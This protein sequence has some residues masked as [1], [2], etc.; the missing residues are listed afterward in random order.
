MKKFFWHCCTAAFLLS[1]ATVSLAA[2]SYE[3]TLLNQIN[4][5]RQKHHL[6]PLQLTEQLNQL[7]AQHSEFMQQQNE[8]NHKMF[9]ERFRAAKRPSCVENVGWNYQ[10]G[11]D[12]FLGWKH[13][14]GHNKNM[15][16]PQITQAGI[17][18]VGAYVTFFACQ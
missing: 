18:K 10:T 14:S 12:Q 8:L 17:A 11:S 3:T 7:A 15:L 13:S 9:K 4:L 6:A 16:A 1:S 5:Y 2:D